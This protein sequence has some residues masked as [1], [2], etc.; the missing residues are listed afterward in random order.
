[1]MGEFGGK[2][3]KKF[4]E[5]E[6]REDLEQDLAERA[7]DPD[8]RE[9][10]LANP[11][12]VLSETYGM[13]LPA[14]ISVTVHEENANNIHFVLPMAESSELSDDDLDAVA[15]GA[16]WLCVIVDACQTDGDV[17]ISD[18]DS[19]IARGGDKGGGK[20]SGGSMSRT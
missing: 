12:S 20:T 9:R 15:G 8:F 5:F 14:D 11:A 6:S 2:M 19:C 1:M 16:N 13:P 10:L 7:Q 17:C 4:N 3:S 18:D